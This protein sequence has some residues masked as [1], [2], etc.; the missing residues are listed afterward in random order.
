MLLWAQL[1]SIIC[2]KLFIADWGRRCA[3]FATNPLSSIKA[4][5]SNDIAVTINSFF[6][7]NQGETP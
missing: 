7:Q 3:E 2:R 5:L 1:L 6:P 4:G